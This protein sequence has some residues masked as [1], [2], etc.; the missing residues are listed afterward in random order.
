MKTFF[1]TD[2]IKIKGVVFNIV[3]KLKTTKPNG[4]PALVLENE[5][6][7]YGLVKRGEKFYIIRTEG[8]DR[9]GIN[10]KEAQVNIKILQP[11]MQEK[12]SDKVKIGL[13]DTKKA[14]IE[15]RIQEVENF[16]NQDF[17]ANSELLSNHWKTKKDLFENKIKQLKSLLQKGIK[18]GEDLRTLTNLLNDVR[19]IL[20][21]GININDKTAI[22]TNEKNIQE[23]A[24]SLFSLISDDVIKD[25]IQV[26]NKAMESRIGSNAVEKMLVGYSDG[27]GYTIDGKNVEYF[28]SKETLENAKNN[29][30]IN[31][32]YDAELAELEKQNLRRL[33][34]TQL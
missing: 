31:A 18:T 27:S 22:L 10:K 34:R 24:K 30:Q 13:E 32:K 11:H 12:F 20:N 9:I 15:R 4:E 23:L 29:K 17:F 5:G 21:E 2:Q 7:K 14:D 3:D 28:L 19:G 33:E 8:L 25:Y 16:V 6:K 1:L 26:M